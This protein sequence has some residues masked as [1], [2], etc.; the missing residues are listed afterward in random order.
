MTS[1]TQQETIDEFD[2]LFIEDNPDDISPLIESFETTDEIAE[3]HVVTDGEEA[4]DFLHQCAD[5][6]NAPKPHL[7]IFGAN[8]SEKS[9]KQLLR[10]LN[11]CQGLESIPVLV[12]TVF[13]STEDVS[14]LYELNANAYLEKPDTPEGFN[15]LAQA[16]EDFWLKTAH[17][18]PR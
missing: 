5:Y 14:R 8:T 11:D 17:L 2:V 15:N 18:P 16:I 6:T 13:D 3:I 10:E 7:I 12:S 4:L 1:S 9:S